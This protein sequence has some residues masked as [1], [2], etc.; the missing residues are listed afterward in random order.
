[1]TGPC[2]AGVTAGTAAAAAVDADKQR[3][4]SPESATDKDGWSGV[5][6][7]CRTSPPPRT[8]PPGYLYLNVKT[9]SIPN[10][11]RKMMSF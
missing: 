1:M 7:R 9:N 10:R 8:V 5:S 2:G 4:V 3:P 6:C 11:N